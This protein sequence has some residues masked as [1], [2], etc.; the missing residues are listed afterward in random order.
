MVSDSKGNSH[1]MMFQELAMSCGPACVAM[2]ESPY[3][4]KCMVDPEKR[5]REISQK[6]EGKWTEKG[7]TNAG[8]LTYVLNDI[9][10]KTYK[11]VDIPDDKIYSY[12]KHYVKE[13]TPTIAH[14]AWS[15]GG[16]FTLIRKVYDDGTI[17][18]LDP[19]YGVVEVKWDK[20]PMYNPIGASGKLSGWLNITYI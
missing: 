4:L 16:H 9:G 5:A 3:K 12:L 14:I 1:Y 19:W 13:R 7:G 17:V 15:K 10:V 8:N 11:C 18:C 2:A 6:Y 20:I